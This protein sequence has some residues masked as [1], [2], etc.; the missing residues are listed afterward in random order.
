[1]AGAPGAVDSANSVLSAL[2]PTELTA[3]TAKLYSRPGDKPVTVT[4]V[5]VG[6]STA[7]LARAAPATEP[8]FWYTL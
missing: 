8:S 7:V 1:M 5:A 3:L 2:S 4:D 6:E